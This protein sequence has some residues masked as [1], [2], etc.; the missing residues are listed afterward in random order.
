[1][2]D[3]I[4]VASDFL[5]TKEKEQAS[6]RRWLLDLL[7]RPIT[8]ASWAELQ[9][10]GSSINRHG[11]FS[12]VHFFE[13]SGIKLDIEATHFWFDDAVI[14]SDSV[15]YLGSH[16]S[17]NNLVIGYELSGQ[18]K[19]LLD[20]IGVPW[21]DIWLHPI[22]FLDDILFGFSASDA[23]VYQ[24]MM[25][26][27]I[28]EDIFYLYAD[29]VR[30]KYYKGYK[31]P[32]L[33]IKPGSALFIG[34]TLEDKAV[35]DGGRML[36]LLDF[37]AAFE[38]AGSQYGTVYYSRHPYVKSGDEAI[39]KYVKS[40]GFSKVVDWPAYQMLASGRIA[41]ILSISSSVLHEA[42]YFDVETEFLFKPVIRYGTQHGDEHLSVYQEFVSP[43]FWAQALAPL[44]PTR[45]CERVM[46]LEQK[47]KL[48]DMLNFYW[49]YRHLDKEEDMR[50][51]LM[52]LDRKVQALLPKKPIAIAPPMPKAKPINQGRSWAAVQTEIE[53]IM[54]R[55]T[56][57]SF[58]IFD[59]LIERP[60]EQPND[61]FDY[62]APQ[63]R[64]LTR[65]PDMDFRK[66]RQEARGLVKDCRHGEEVTLAERY[67]A[68]AANLGLP[69]GLSK[70]MQMMEESIELRFCSPRKTGKALYEAAL[71][72][73]KK[74]VLVS[75]T[76]FES[77]FMSRLLEVN[78]YSR[79]AA[80]F[81]SSVEG[82]L[83]HTGNLYQVVLNSLGVSPKDVLH[84]GDNAHADIKQ[85]LAA[86]LASYHLP[87]A[88]ETFA[89]N[90]RLAGKMAGGG[91]VLR[92]VMRGL[93]VNRL[94]DNPHGL[95]TPSH[96]GQDPS[97]FGYAVAGP[98]FFGFAK[99]VLQQAIANKVETLYFLARDGDIIKRCYDVL[100]P[101]YP[102]A[103][104]SVYLR[105]SRRGVNVPALETE[106]DLIAMLEVNFTPTTLDKLFMNRFGLETLPFEALTEAGYGSL[107]DQV[108]YKR[109]EARLR[110]LLTLLTPHI[111]SNARDERENLL[112]YYREMGLMAPSSKA[113]VDI[114]HNGTLQASISRLVGDHQLGGYYFVTYQEIEKN[115]LA[116]GMPA[117]GYLAERINGSD[118]RHPYCNYLLMFE[119]L[120]LNTEGSFIRMRREKS[121]WQ[122]VMLSTD[123]EAS[124]VRFI[125]QVHDAAVEFTR[126][127]AHTFGAELAEL[128]VDGAGVVSGYLSMLKAPTEIDALLFDGIEFENVYSGRDTRSVIK[129]V[130]NDAVTTVS[131]SLWKEGAI[132]LAAGMGKAE[133]LITR[134]VREIV[135]RSV[136]ERKYR[137]FL[138]SPKQFFTD[139]KLPLIRRFAVLVE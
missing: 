26:F 22:R 41:K 68:L 134:L 98:I 113:V 103:P 51:T 117:Q 121:T 126:D 110:H 124:R 62:M 32:D 116:R 86:G 21:I 70:K 100:A 139:S 17:P 72:Q 131:Q 101:H 45:N 5:M 58:D 135:R 28:K 37:K 13:L 84:I 92:S 81:L 46:Y 47:D 16:V 91:P 93:V 107:D 115:V 7:R 125:S 30:I 118:K 130:A 65:M 55:H 27:H 6:N 75:D 85:A 105:A 8:K 15:A 57:V 104:R 132:V 97:D 74:V 43:H 119:A 29:R 80:V 1:M 69:E 42:R 123:L 50:Q 111:L 122:P 95:S 63:M 120:F 60:F 54:A 3:M 59:T 137:K 49:S 133:S 66:V 129:R 108:D 53:T 39:L 9:S 61:L 38:R 52:A 109:D 127:M 73:G 136:S 67:H 14:T 34:Q 2:I 79:H 48:R 11:A 88:S 83:K 76:F 99:W 77:E 78:G 94:A 64:E 102:G 12:R 35:C 138:N 106:A 20:R 40:C 33:P 56:V 71:R 23:S 128:R 24:A 90:S 87:K 44:M 4:L 82:K 31:R 112:G 25:P 36:N 10:F 96:A 89:K 114:G 18:T 19:R